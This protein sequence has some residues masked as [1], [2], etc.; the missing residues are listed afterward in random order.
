MGRATMPATSSPAHHMT[1]ASTDSGAYAFGGSFRPA[2][3]VATAVSARPPGYAASPAVAMV[4]ELATAPIA[5]REIA[6][7]GGPTTPV[8]RPSPAGMRV[9]SMVGHRDEQRPY[10]VSPT[11]PSR[12]AVM[13]AT[14]N[15]SWNPPG[16]P[17]A[18]D[19]VRP[20]EVLVLV[21]PTI[22]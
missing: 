13:W 14:S 17:P 20:G 18:L 15:R 3:T 22:P 6:P 5:V 11:Q 16:T 10:N 21:A 19:T 2:C 1:E 12:F 9:R 4:V 8:R 7:R